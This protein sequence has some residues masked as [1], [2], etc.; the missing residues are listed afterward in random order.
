[1]WSLPKLVVHQQCRENATQVIDQA[2]DITEV[3]GWMA[4]SRRITTVV[5]DQSE[6]DP[7]VSMAEVMRRII[8]SPQES[9]TVVADPSGIS[10]AVDMT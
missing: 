7:A 2:V 5:V 6:S 10:Q 4:I 8:I 3:T 9:T 1:L